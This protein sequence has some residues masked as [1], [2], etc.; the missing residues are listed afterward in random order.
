MK[1]IQDYFQ[2]AE[3]RDD[4]VQKKWRE[5]PSSA[6]KPETRPVPRPK[7]DVTTTQPCP[8]V[9]PTTPPT[10]TQSDD[11]SDDVYLEEEPSLRKIRGKYKFYTVAE[12]KELLDLAEMY[13]TCV[14]SSKYGLPK[15][16]LS[17][18]KKTFCPDSPKT[19]KGREI[20]GG[21]KL[22]YSENVELK[23]VGW[24]RNRQELQLPVSRHSIQLYAQNLVLSVN[25]Q[26]TFKASDGW[27]A[28]F[29]R[30]NNLSL[31]RTSTS[32]AGHKQ[33]GDITDL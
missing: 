16:T 22:V 31:R 21:G 26:P 1:R 24:I 23:I 4:S 9:P 12:K 17:T 33:P 13:G 18:W 28:R 8:R 25:Q 2:K 32:A 3:S 11:E 27:L 10:N 6:T 30:R 29:L 15:S 7:F 20:G 19:Q 5:P 14:I